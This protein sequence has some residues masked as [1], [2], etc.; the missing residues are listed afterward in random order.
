LVCFQLIR[1]DFRYSGL[2]KGP[3]V[4]LLENKRSL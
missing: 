2:F 1:K 4:R 3:V